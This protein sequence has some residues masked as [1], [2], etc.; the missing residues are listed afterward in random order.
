MDKYF[1]FKATICVS[2][3]LLTRCLIAGN[4]FNRTRFEKFS[5]TK[6]TSQLAQVKTK[7]EKIQVTVHPTVNYV[8]TL[9]VSIKKYTQLSLVSFRS[10]KLDFWR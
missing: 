4:A 8:F 6:S 9:N 2:L 3:I 10:Y 5:P 1:L 7:A